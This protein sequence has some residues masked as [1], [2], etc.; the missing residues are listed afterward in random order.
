MAANVKSA[1]I[2]RAVAKRTYASAATKYALGCSDVSC[3]VLPNKLVVACVDSGLPISRV[4][5]LYRGGSRYET[6]ENLGVSNVLRS[7]AGLT[8]ED[9]TKF[10][11][12]RHLQQIGASLSVTSD[13]ESIAYTLEG[14]PDKIELGLK[15]L[16]SVATKQVFKPWELDDN[17]PRIKYELAT[18][19]PQTIVADL[20][21]TAAYRTGLGNSLFVKDYNIS[22]IGAETLQ[23]FVQSTFRTNRCAVVGVGVDNNTLVSL[24]QDLGIESGPGEQS[25]A[26][27]YGGEVHKDAASSFA[28]VAICAEAAG[29]NSKDAL[30]FAVL[31]YA[32]GSGS[33]VK[34][35]SGAGPL[36]KAAATSDEPLALAAFNAAYSDS[37]LFGVFIS[38]TAENAKKGVEA[39]AKVLSGSVTDADVKRGK[40]LLKAA[41]LQSYENGESVIQD[42]GNQAL[43]LGSVIPLAQLAT[44][45]D[46][47][48]TSQ[49][50]DAARKVSSGKKSFAGYGNLSK[51]PYLDEV[52]K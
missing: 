50:Q 5:I 48:T 38:T 6:A 41:V 12:I 33:A 31:R 30:A 36:G 16:K 39:A 20:L 42:V 45:V 1:P 2:L 34:Y 3:N 21:H 18:L 22:K 40:A 32:L 51:T 9:F 44:A 25:P 17:I 4:S 46:A 47:V 28:H 23:Y 19:A 49:V 29:L 13:R 11:I 37:G 10:G 27:Y 24:A 26:K 7:S 15:Y 35:G 8:T 14:T 43:L 52:A